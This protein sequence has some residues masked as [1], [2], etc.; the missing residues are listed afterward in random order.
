LNLLEDV[1]GF[2][3]L[4]NTLEHPEYL[5]ELEIEEEQPK[6]LEEL[7]NEVLE[8]EEWNEA[9]NPKTT[10]QDRKERGRKNVKILTGRNGVLARIPVLFKT[11]VYNIHRLYHTVNVV[12][13]WSFCLLLLRKPKKMLFKKKKVKGSGKM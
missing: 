8:K 9:Y 13:L 4:E 12:H 7:T 1:F 6:N 3:H 2:L 10:K 5:E 11:R